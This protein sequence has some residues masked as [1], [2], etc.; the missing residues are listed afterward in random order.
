MPIDKID[1]IT[2]PQNALQNPSI[3]T[4]GTKYATNMNK[5]ALI[6]RMNSPRV[7]ILIGKVRKINT[8]FITMFTKAIAAEAINAVK[9]LEIVIP[10]IIHPT[11]IIASAKAN[12]LSKSI[13]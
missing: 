7:K 2:A 10:G 3:S 9:K 12:H 6:T 4:P 8:G 11:N 5:R 13:I 1:S